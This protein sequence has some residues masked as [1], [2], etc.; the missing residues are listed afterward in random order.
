[1]LALILSF[2]A[3]GQEPARSDDA[4]D[5]PTTKFTVK[6][7][8]VRKAAGRFTYRGNVQLTVR[9]PGL[10]VQADELTWNEATQE[11]VASGPVRLRL[12][13]R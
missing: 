7:E 3:S 6:A 11:F 9:Q 13:T 8:S 12:A 4:T 5:P 10:E 1:V 2:V